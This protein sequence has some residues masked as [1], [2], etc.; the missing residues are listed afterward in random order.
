MP[1][2]SLRYS[3]LT[4]RR[5]L[6][7][8]GLFAALALFVWLIQAPSGFPENK[9]IEIADGTNLAEITEQLTKIKVIKTPGLFRLFVRFLG[10]SRGVMAGDY[11]FESRLSGWS[12]AQRLVRGQFVLNPVR[13]TI[14]E[15][16]SPAQVAQI[17]AGKLAVR[18]D[19]ARQELLSLLSERPAENFPDTYF[20]PPEI[21][22]D[23]L[24]K[25]LR[26][27]FLRQTAS[28][29]SRSLVSSRS[30]EDVLNMAAI[31][32]EEAHDYHT[33]QLIAGILWKRLDDNMPLQVDV[34]PVT[35][36]R[37]G[38]PERAIVAP[39]L[40]AIEATLNPQPSDYWFYLAD[41]TGETHYAVDFAEHKQNKVKY[42]R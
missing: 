9:Q 28:L 6:L 34:A 27:N 37:R 7:C 26:Q 31:V 36:E 4:R 33:R 38:L 20:F 42:L 25:I 17:I 15:G 5:Q 3:K 11:W 16:S 32:E 13:V 40:Q 22:A 12:V 1:R 8:I 10:G 19:S 23:K 41:K 2:L 29:H 21:S 39:G 18:S 24:V 35:Y 14:P 30:W